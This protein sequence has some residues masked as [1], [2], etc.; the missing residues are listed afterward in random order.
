VSALGLIDL[1]KKGVVEVWDDVYDAK[2][3]DKAAPDLGDIVKGREEPIYSNPE[4]FFNRT[5]LTSSMRELIEDVSETLSKGKGG[6]IFLLTSLFGGGKTH[7]QIALYHAFNS[8]DKLRILDESL[9]SKVAEVGKPLIVVMDGSRA[10]LV[11]HPKEPYRAEGFTIKT[12]WGMLAYRLGAY[13]KIKHRDSEGAAAPEVNLL[14]EVLAEAKGPILILMDEIVHYIFNMYKSPELRDYGE[15]VKLFLDYLARAVEDTPRTALVVSVQAEYRVVEGQRVLFEEEVFKDYAKAVLTVLSRESTKIIPPVSPEDVVMVLKRRLFKKIPDDKAIEAKDKLYRTY[16]EIPQLFGVES[17]W[18]LSLSEA[19]RLASAKETYPFH[20]KYIE[21]LQEF[22]TRNRDLQKTR[23]AVRIT[24]KVVRRFLRSREDS[25]FIMPWHIDL[26]DLDI[27][28]RVLTDSYREFRDV[29][30]RDIV[31]EDGRLGSVAEC[32]KP[33]LALKIATV[34]LLKTY[35]YETFKE[36]LKVFPDKKSIALMVYEPETFTREK[37]TPLDIETSLGEMHALPH[38]VEEGGR[39]WFTPYFPV[40]EYVERRAQELLKGPKAPLY[41][42]L[43]ESVSELLVKRERRGVVER[44]EVFDEKNTIVVGFG[45]YLWEGALVKDDPSVKLVVFIKPDVN[46]E[47][48]R[49]LILTRGEGSRRTYRNTVVALCPH[50]NADF[51]RLHLLAAKILASQEVMGSLAEYYTDKEVRGI[52]EAKLKRYE[53]G[54]RNNLN[55]NLLSTLTRIAYPRRSST[56]DEVDYVETTASSSIISQVE[57]GLKD[58]STGPKLRTDFSFSDLAELLKSNLNWDLVEGAGRRE[59]RE[60]VNFFYTSTVAPITTR[61]AVERALLDGLKR[62]DI[63]VKVDDKLYWKR[64][65]PED[66]AEL[67][68]SPLRDS[69]EILPYKL[70]ANILKDKLLAEEREEIVDKE[71]RVV[72]YEVEVAGKRV[73][74]RDLILEKGWEKALKAGV[75]LRQEEIIPRGFLLKVEPSSVK[76]KPG[77]NVEAKVSVKPVGEYPYVVKLTAEK[78]TL[79]PNEGK[80]PLE[81]LWSLGVFEEPGNY[82]FDLNALGEDGVTRSV[83]LLI[84]VESLEEEVVVEKL[85]ITHVGAKLINISPKDITSYRQAVEIISKLNLDAE[86][87]LTV[88]FGKEITFT[89]GGMEVKLAAIFL[90]KFREIIMALPDIEKKTVVGGGIKLRQPLIIDESKISAFAPLS[91]KALFKL[92]VKKIE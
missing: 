20:P 8:P 15:R 46:E 22:V 39:Y 9:A 67:P 56:G 42:V 18:Q 25:E 27:R 24:R 75:L 68:S 48:I 64:V 60:I 29:A 4:E 7:T 32:S 92:R 61:S 76:V 31:S 85:D 41:R 55:L 50:L 5:Y 79:S 80:C 40:T 81:S 3:D 84:S 12:I 62:L 59:F 44:S 16:R 91:N 72:W 34:V 11:P 86:A 45:D 73:K 28:N 54:I 13:A 6:R 52:M 82:A 2:L 47:E 78:G 19:G 70:A 1:V 89:G 43:K 65:G 77:E 57:A 21:V 71:L 26:R 38:F 17:E 90:S 51:D 74:L 37:W 88:Q 83:T 14:R 53:D 58:P 66:G 30:S 69:A 35:T 36:P 63:G 33:P 87:N 49:S 23:D 10:D